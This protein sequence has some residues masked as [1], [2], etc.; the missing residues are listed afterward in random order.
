MSDITLQVYYQ[1]IQN[2]LVGF[3][4]FNKIHK[5]RVSFAKLMKLILDRKGFHYIDKKRKNL[6]LGCDFVSTLV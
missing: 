6:V 4:G 5:S 2:S 3:V 1:F